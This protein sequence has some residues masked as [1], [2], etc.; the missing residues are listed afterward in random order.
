MDKDTI[1][2]LINTIFKKITKEITKKEG[3]YDYYINN[4]IELKNEVMNILNSIGI[5][6]NSD[7]AELINQGLL[8]TLSIWSE[9]YNEYENS[10]F[11]LDVFLGD[12][13]SIVFDIEMLFSN[14]DE[15]LLRKDIHSNKDE[16]LKDFN[17]LISFIYDRKEE[18]ENV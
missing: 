13:D 5:N 10:Q 14:W 12:F 8:E 1:K 18:L 17:E 2:M 6:Y 7:D 16:M 15:I 4:P 11:E 9:D 3:K